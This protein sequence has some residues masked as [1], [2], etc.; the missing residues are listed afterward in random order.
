MIWELSVPAPNSVTGIHAIEQN[1]TSGFGCRLWRSVMNPVWWIFL[2]SA[3]LAAASTLYKKSKGKEV[4]DMSDIDFL[5]NYKQLFDDSDEKVIA[6]RNMVARI[7]GVSSRKL[8]PSRT[9]VSLS[10]YTGF[11]TEY[12][13][14]MSELGDELAYLA[15]QAGL[16]D[17]VSFPNTVG[18]LIHEIIIINKRSG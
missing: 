2:A 16:K 9:F 3:A 17:P 12:E 1:L 7:L 4:P 5:R 11:I 6:T 14:G 13:L 18:E 8:S 10:K 15:K